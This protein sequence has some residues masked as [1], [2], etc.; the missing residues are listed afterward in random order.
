MIAVTRQLL[1]PLAYLRIRGHGKILIDL[2]VPAA[3][4]AGSTFVL[5]WVDAPVLTNE[6]LVER[7]NELLQVLVG[8]YVASL[9]AV[10]TFPSVALDQTALNTTFKKQSILRRQ[11]LAYLFG[12]LSFLSLSLY[13]AGVLG[14]LSRS[15]ISASFEAGGVAWGGL[16]FVYL[17]IV[18]NMTCVT[19][20]GIHYLVDR[21]FRPD[22]IVATFG[23][24]PSQDGDKGNGEPSEQS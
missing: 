7:M 23:N 4:A 3:L 10:S 21:T 5:W 22:P 24:S 17:V 14:L 16:L 8:F 11:L 2:V 6:G 12:Y 1:T 9:A 13:I 20:L 18:W 19:L 15:L